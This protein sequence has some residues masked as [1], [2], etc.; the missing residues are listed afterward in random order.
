[1]SET[2]NFLPSIGLILGLQLVGESLAQLLGLSIP[3]PVMGM[4]L[5]LGLLTIFPSLAGFV[6]GTALGV[7]SYLSLLFVPAGVGVVRHLQTLGTDAAAILI[8]VVASTLITLVVTAFAFSLTLR[9]RGK[10]DA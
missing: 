4:A 1:M 8:V 6:K 10:K 9:L 3:G 5:F 2:Q 7:L